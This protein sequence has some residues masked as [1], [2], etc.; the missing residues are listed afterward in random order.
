[1]E[2]TSLHISI[3]C[4]SVISKSVSEYSFF[5]WASW[6]NLKSSSK[7]QFSRIARLM[8]PCAQYDW[9]NI[10]IEIPRPLPKWRCLMHIFTRPAE[11]LDNSGVPRQSSI[12]TPS[13]GGCSIGYFQVGGPSKKSRSW[14][15]KRVSGSK[16]LISIRDRCRDLNTL[17]PMLIRWA[18]T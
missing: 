5:I 12:I 13:L 1:M 8:P 2:C 7:V 11:G 18:V 3:N 16:R 14:Y 6:F 10:K 4:S 17:T 9:T 15:S